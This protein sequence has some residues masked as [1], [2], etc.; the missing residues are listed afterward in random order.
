M[1]EVIFA[2]KIQIEIKFVNVPNQPVQKTIG[3]SRFAGINRNIL[4]KQDLIHNPGSRYMG[5][6]HPERPISTTDA[7]YLMTLTTTV[8]KGEV[9]QGRPATIEELVCY[10]AMSHEELGHT[11][12]LALG[13]KV[14]RS[15]A[16]RSKYCIL[17]LYVWGVDWYTDFSVLIVFEKVLKPD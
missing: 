7:H 17:E 15:V 9:Y 13:E 2:S 6:W 5:I 12:I 14:G 1:N 11:Q 10:Q 8:I 4:S 3:T 16:Y